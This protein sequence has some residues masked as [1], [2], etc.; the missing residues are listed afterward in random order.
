MYNANER[1]QFSANWIYY[2]GDAVT[3]PTGKYMVDH[4]V[5]YYYSERNAYRLPNYHRLDLGATR[6]FKKRRKFTSELAFNIFNIYG[7]SNAY[8]INFRQSETDPDKTEAVQTS[9]FNFVPSISYNFR[10]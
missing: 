2:T 8:Q 7:R 5:F 4:E 9:L 6:F 3:F 1:W 10:F